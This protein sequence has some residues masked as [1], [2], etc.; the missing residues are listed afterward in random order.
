MG[1]RK[2]KRKPPPK[3]KAIEKMDTFFNCPF[4]NHERACEVKM[5]VLTVCTTCIFS[6]RSDRN[7]KVMQIY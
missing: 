3:R 1:R 2:A 5:Y 7:R 4:C 6:A